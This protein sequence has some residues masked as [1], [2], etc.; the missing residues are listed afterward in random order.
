VNGRSLLILGLVTA[1]VLS[2]VAIVLATVHNL[3]G[4]YDPLL[5]VQTAS[6]IA[7]IWYVYFTFH[8]VLRRSYPRV[9]FRLDRHDANQLGLHVTNHSLDRAISVRHRVD[10]RRDGEFLPMEPLFQGAKNHAINLQPG[11]D[12]IRSLPIEPLKP[13]E[14][15]DYGPRAQAGEPESMLVRTVVCWEDDEGFS[16]RVGPQYWEVRLV[17]TQVKELRVRNETSRRF[18]GFPPF[19]CA[20]P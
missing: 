8:S 9:E 20:N 16:G 2:I 18:E 10:I 12:D 7:L 1:I 19:S 15:S 5:A 6:L 4:P 13:V 11:K 3:G 14:G 17:D